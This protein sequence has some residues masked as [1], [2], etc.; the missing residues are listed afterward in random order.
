MPSTRG[1][2]TSWAAR[3]VMCGRP[4]TSRALWT[5]CIAGEPWRM[6]SR[7]PS[8]RDWYLRLLRTRGPAPERTLARPKSPCSTCGNGGRSTGRAGGP[9]Y[10]ERRSQTR[11][12][13]SASAKPLSEGD[14]W[15]MKILC[16]RWR[17]PPDANYSPNRE[18]VPRNQKV[19]RQIQ[20][21]QW[22]Q[23]G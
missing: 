7:I 17:L 13:R 5:P 10:S 8:G 16:G 21:I 9:P 2:S 15:A 18:A 4:G 22:N 19:R 23:K 12:L 6:W 3:A 1:T 11:R 14:P 20:W